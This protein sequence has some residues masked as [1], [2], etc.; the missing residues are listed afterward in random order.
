MKKYIYLLQAWIMWRRKNWNW[1]EL[2]TPPT[3]GWARPTP[4]RIPTRQRST[5]P[6]PFSPTIGLYIR[7]AFLYLVVVVVVYYATIVT[8]GHGLL[9]KLWYIV[10]GCVLLT[11]GRLII[12]NY[13]DPLTSLEL[14]NYNLTVMSIV[15]GFAYYVVQWHHQRQSDGIQDCRFFSHFILG[16]TDKQKDRRTQW[17]T[18]TAASFLS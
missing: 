11:T 12:W 6:G 15:A 10:I 16:H 4:P 9:K 7:P 14:L 18:E 2:Q 8:I 1:M 17:L 5:D 13:A 3:L